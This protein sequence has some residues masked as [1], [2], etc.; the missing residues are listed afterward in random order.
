MPAVPHLVCGILV[1]AVLSRFS[2]SFEQLTQSLERAGVGLPLVTQILV[3][4]PPLIWTLVGL[5]IAAG[6]LVCGFVPQARRRVITLHVIGALFGLVSCMALWLP[7]S[8][9]GGILGE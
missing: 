6:V 4:S 8:K 3:S 5:L 2:E 7:L 1:T 9:M